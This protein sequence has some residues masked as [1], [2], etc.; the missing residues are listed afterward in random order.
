MPLRK[1]AV[2]NVVGLTPELLGPDMP[3]LTAWAGRG[4]TTSVQPVLPAV[5]CSARAT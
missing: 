2:I 4:K 1:T 3:R 5:T